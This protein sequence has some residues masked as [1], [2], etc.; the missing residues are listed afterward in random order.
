[1]DMMS[2]SLV[3]VVILATCSGCGAPIKQTSQVSQPIGQSLVAGVGDTIITINNEK[4]LPNAFGKADIFGRTTPT[5]MITVQYLGSNGPIAKFIRSGVEI[6]TNATTMNSTP[7]V[8]PNV[9]TTTT[10]G[11][12]GSTPVTGTA[13]TYGAPT[14]IPAH[15]P[16]TQVLSQAQVSF[17]IDVSKERSFSVS[18][19]TVLII[20]ATPTSLTYNIQ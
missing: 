10:S 1:M 4:N 11:Y 5:G 3:A 19:K 13:T 17:Q 16:E 6:N 7:T 15:P 8:I 2:Q 18:G 20:N 12:I 9:Q 14:V